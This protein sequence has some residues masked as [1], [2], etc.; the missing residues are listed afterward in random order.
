MDSP[1][2]LRGIERV[3]RS[4]GWALGTRLRVRLNPE[5]RAA[6]L[7]LRADGTDSVSGKR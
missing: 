6:E 2:V 5:T 7:V 4:R 3:A 1:H